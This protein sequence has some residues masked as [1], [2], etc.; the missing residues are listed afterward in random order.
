[1]ACALVARQHLRNRS[2]RTQSRL[3]P[4]RLR[5][6]MGRQQPLRR[7]SASHQLQSAVG[8][9]WRQPRPRVLQWDKAR[10]RAAPMPRRWDTKRRLPARTASPPAVPQRRIRPMTSRSAMARSQTAETLLPRERAR[11][12]PP[13]MRLLLVQ[14]RLLPVR[15]RSALAPGTSLTGAVRGRS[16]IPLQSLEADRIRWATTTPLI[17]T[18]HLSLAI[19]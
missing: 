6:R 19:M 10:L 1:M 7:R 13:V 5:R 4:L 16:A 17:R 8:R 9:R 12:R 15:G 3:V 18:T 14:M 11:W 2:G